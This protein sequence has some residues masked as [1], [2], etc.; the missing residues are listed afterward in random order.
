MRTASQHTPAQRRIRESLN[1]G[2]SKGNLIAQHLIQHA[3][4]HESLFRLP[5]RPPS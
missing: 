5:D 4:V 3:L 1:Q 2:S